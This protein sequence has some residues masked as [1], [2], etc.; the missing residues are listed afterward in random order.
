MKH[1]LRFSDFLKRYLT[2]LLGVGLFAAV[3]LIYASTV[4]PVQ[5][6]GDPSEYTFIP[7]ILG[8]AHPPGYGFYTNDLT[9]FD[10]LRESMRDSS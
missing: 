9:R 6:F 5:V 3:W 4:P 1:F 2:T 7:W 10:V 8:I